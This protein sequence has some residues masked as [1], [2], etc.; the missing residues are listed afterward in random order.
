MVVNSRQKRSE[1]FL[2]EAGVKLVLVIGMWVTELGMWVTGYELSTR[3]GDESV[4]L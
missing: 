2:S 4:D 3:R 1:L